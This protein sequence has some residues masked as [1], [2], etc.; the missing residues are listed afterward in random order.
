MH[1]LQRY[2]QRLLAILGTALLLFVVFGLIASIYSFVERQLR[3]RDRDDS[4]VQVQNTITVESGD[5]VKTFRNQVITYNEPRSIDTIGKKFVTTVGQVNLIEPEEVVSDRTLGLLDSYE[6]L[7]SSRRIKGFGNQGNFNNLIYSDL[8]LGITKQ[9]FDRKVAISA[10]QYF[11]LN[12]IEV[13]VMRGVDEDSNR[14]NRL[15][16][17]DFQSLFVY[18]LS[19]FTLQKFDFETE[20]VLSVSR[21]KRTNLLLVNSG[22]DKDENL[23]FN[24][25]N[26][27]ELFYFFDA[28]KRKLKP[29]ISKETTQKLQ[30][31]LDR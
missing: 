6:S 14:D 1:K 10:W 27:P 26:E 13:I 30:Q 15:N 16:S 11:K 22:V 24:Y 4:T 21:L 2:N 3:I 5:S 23:Y 29:L 9:I 8:D 18:Y 31:I 17:E 28:N 12:E 20:T 25:G 19:D 7:S